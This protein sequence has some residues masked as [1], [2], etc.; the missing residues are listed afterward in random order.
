M[1]DIKVDERLRQRLRGKV[2]SPVA[3]DYEKVRAIWNGQITRQPALIARC[4]R[5]A[6]V[7]EAIRFARERGLP[8]S[9]RCGGHAVAGHAL[10]DG[11]LLIDLSLMTAVRVDPT[12]RTARAQGGCLGVHLD[13][14]AQLHGLAVTG[15][16]VS[17]TGIGGLTL[18]GEIDHLMRPEDPQ[19]DTRPELALTLPL[20]CR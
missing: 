15:G 3:P 20:R 17:H 9:V 5:T 10:C 14:E 12:A 11:G 6:D 7:I 19:T 16:I 18:G 13:R 1:S 4:L 2:V 8:A